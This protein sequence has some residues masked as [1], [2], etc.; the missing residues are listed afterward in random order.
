MALRRIHKELA[1][2]RKE[3]PAQWYVAPIGDDLYKC[4]GVVLGAKNTPYEG[5]IFFVSVL[6]PKDYPFKPPK[7]RFETPIYHLGINKKG[8]HCAIENISKGYWS[9]AL[10]I[11]KLFL[12]ICDYLTYTYEHEFLR[13]DLANLYKT[14]RQKY[15]KMAAMSTS[16]HAHTQLYLQHIGGHKGSKVSFLLGCHKRVG[17]NSSVHKYLVKSAMFD[18]NLVQLIVQFLPPTTLH[19]SMFLRPTC[20]DLCCVRKLP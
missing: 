11:G 10:T 3:N 14:N 12:S 6:F 13:L 1:S 17:Q 2:I 4:R 7:T 19:A 15:N 8:G 20:P 18:A 9:P 16:K 5:G